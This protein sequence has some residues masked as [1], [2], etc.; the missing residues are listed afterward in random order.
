MHS[1]FRV[2]VNF[3]RHALW[4]RYGFGLLSILNYRSML[5]VAV[6]CKYTFRPEHCTQCCQVQDLWYAYHTSLACRITQGRWQINKHWCS[7][8]DLRDIALTE[9][10]GLLW[11]LTRSWTL[12][13]HL[14]RSSLVKKCLV[15]SA[16]CE[17]V[18]QYE[19]LLVMCLHTGNLTSFCI[20]L[21]NFIQWIH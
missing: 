5:L 19:P 18:T 21:F 8:H 15:N 3:L 14:R 1:V 20:Y 17:Q 10:S 16:R 9:N 11:I 7:N 13:R 6:V 12:R 4:P 2:Q